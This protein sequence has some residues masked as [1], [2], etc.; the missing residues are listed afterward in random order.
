MPTASCSHLDQ[1]MVTNLPESVA[2]CEECLE[3]GD[4]WLHLRICLECGKVSCCD[5][6]PNRHASSHASETGHPLIR[7]LE[8]GERW[9]FCFVD[10]I[11]LEIPEI[12]GETRI[13]PSPLL[14]GG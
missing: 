4:P 2:G 5:S 14:A 6:S 13:P 11:G 9:S 8:P 12:R 1:V 7:S 3:T 10:E